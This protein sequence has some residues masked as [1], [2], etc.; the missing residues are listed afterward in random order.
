MSNLWPEKIAITSKEE[1]EKF[2]TSYPNHDNLDK[3][4]LSEMIAAIYYSNHFKCNRICIRS[5]IA[6]IVYKCMTCVPISSRYPVSSYILNRLQDL[7]RP[8]KASV[9]EV[10]DCF[11]KQHLE[12][13]GI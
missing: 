11:E 6:E 13:Y 4:S 1:L 2:L 5:L 12:I 9:I 7:I 10:L 3:L 8:E